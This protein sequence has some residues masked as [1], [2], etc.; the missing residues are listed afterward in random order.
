MSPLVYYG[1]KAI[2]AVGRR[3][4][5]WIS[6]PFHR[7]AARDVGVF[8]GG[9]GAIATAG[10]AVAGG[11][12]TIAATAPYA[13]GAGGLKAYERCGGCHFGPKSPGYYA[14]SMGYC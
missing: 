6:K 14:S 1:T 13:V 10:I 5:N 7:D 11:V 3:A 12:A 9:T 4:S 2:I 8:T